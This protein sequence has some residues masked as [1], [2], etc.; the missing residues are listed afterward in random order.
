M[1][2]QT[3]ELPSQGVRACAGCTPSRHHAPQW[4]SLSPSHCHGAAGARMLPDNSLRGS[5]SGSGS[6]SVGTSAINTMPS[7]FSS[8]RCQMLSLAVMLRLSLFCSSLSWCK[9]TMTS[10]IQGPAQKTQSQPGL[11][12]TTEHVRLRSSDDWTRASSGSLE[13][14]LIVTLSR[15]PSQVE[16]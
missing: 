15:D 13:L 5:G 3:R 9:T 6:G 2:A 8:K 10:S 7:L 4:S 1:A 12:S 16:P 11:P 14:S